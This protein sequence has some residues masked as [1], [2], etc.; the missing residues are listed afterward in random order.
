MF[1]LQAK[2]HAKMGIKE[3]KSRLKQKVLIS[4]IKLLIHNFCINTHP[5]TVT[6]S[7]AG[8]R[9]ERLLRRARAH[10]TTLYTQQ[11]L[12]H[13]GPE[14]ANHSSLRAGGIKKI[15]ILQR[16]SNVNSCLSEKCIVIINMQSCF[17]GHPK[18]NIFLL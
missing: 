12:A 4:V 2:D 5:F 16:A 13:L 14:A 1:P 11:R 7:L 3:V 6:G 18:I 8:A 9:R 15:T 10:S 17:H